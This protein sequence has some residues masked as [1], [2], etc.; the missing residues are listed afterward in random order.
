[1]N[2]DASHLFD[3][4]YE[5]RTKRSSI[6]Q[7]GKVGIADHFSGRDRANVT[8]MSTHFVSCRFVRRSFGSSRSHPWIGRPRMTIGVALVVSTSLS[9]AAGSTRTRSPPWPIAATAMLPPTR[10]ARPPNIF[11]SESSRSV[12][13]TSLMRWARC[14]SYGIV[15]LIPGGFPSEEFGEAH[16]A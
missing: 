15:F 4:L 12:H 10:N 1:M 6:V 13:T 5:M 14:L 11:F 3:D 7:S 2:G 16:K 8:P 9:E